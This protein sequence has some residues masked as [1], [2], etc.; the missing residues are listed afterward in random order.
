MR[1]ISRRLA[2]L[3]EAIV[4][5]RQMLASNAGSFSAK[6][7]LKS[8]EDI[9]HRIE[10]E[11]SVLVAHR[12]QE[13][14]NL[15]LDGAAFSEHSAD[16]G[17]LGLV[18]VRIQ[19]LYTSVAQ[20]ITVGPRLRGPISRDISIATNLKLANVF[21][22]SFGVNLFVDQNFD[23]FGDSTATSALE[24]LF[25]LLHSSRD[26]QAILRSSGEVGQRAVN[27]FRRMLNDLAISGSSISVS[28]S[29]L[30]GTE[31][32]WS[33]DSSE[34]FHIRD[35]LRALKMSSAKEVVLDGVIV[36]ASLVR[37]RFEFMSDQF[38]LIEGKIARSA[39]PDIRRFFG[40]RC[41]VTADRVDM[42][43]VSRSVV[44]TYYTMTGVG[45]FDGADLE[46]LT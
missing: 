36:G 1:S 5:S 35:H 23:I 21:P 24:A 22:S 44:R 43:D 41:S 45:E 38:G 32:L 40:S 2:E 26:D 13:R 39:K 9:R 37:D 20:S 31:Y 7:G 8:L 6:I 30:S 3:D 28:W 25:S 11:R 4:A 17:I 29:D 10:S 16:V 33:A 12:L 46:S 14:V 18:L 19:K 42:S 27:H 34:I 15:S